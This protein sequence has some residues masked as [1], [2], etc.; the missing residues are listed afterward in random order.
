MRTIGQII[1]GHAARQP[2]R[3][4]VV[5]IDKVPLSFAQ[6]QRQIDEIGI[7]LG[8]LAR[9]CQA[10]IGLAVLKGPEAVVLIAA[11]ACHATVVPINNSLSQDELRQLFD[12][13][14]LDA[15]IMSKATAAEMR[16]IAHDL[17]I[18]IIDAITKDGPNIDCELIVPNN[19][20]AAACSEA[21]PDPIAVIIQ[22]SGT[23]GQP[24]LVPI[25][26]GNFIAEAANLKSWF[27]LGPDDRS[28][29]FVP[30]QY[31]HGIR[32]T[33]FP[34]LITGGSIARPAD[35]LEL[36]ADWLRVLKPTWYSA[37]PIHHRCLFQAL[38]GMPGT[39]KPLSLRFALSSGTPLDPDLQCSLSRLLGAPVLEFYGFAEAG[40]VTANLP[41]PRKNKPGT[42]GIPLDDQMIISRDGRSVR[43]GELGEV[44]VRGESVIAGYLNNPEANREKFVNGWFRTGDLGSLDT[45]GFLSLHGRLSELINRGGESRPAKSNRHWL[46]TPPS[47]KRLP[48]RCHTRAWV[49]M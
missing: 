28:L 16:Y 10:R 30:L 1:R 9:A 13:A 23:T 27:N 17:K 3:P 14:R 37:F 41:P 38:R 43:P 6:L 31:A 42:C 39:S 11:L 26:H 20:A 19:T 44:L 35:H 29:S 25:T 15:L 34:A 32:E 18:P 21:A 5:S 12:A 4:A 2:D 24:K 36:S 22:T 47:A 46:S 8:P 7:Q 40:H 49:R 33:L 45:E 48:S